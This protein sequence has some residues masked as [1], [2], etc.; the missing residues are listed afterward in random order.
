FTPP[1][2]GIRPHHTSPPVDPGEF[3]YFCHQVL[4]RYK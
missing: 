3:A 4:Q 2:R 1:S